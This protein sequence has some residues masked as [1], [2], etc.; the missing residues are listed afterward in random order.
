LCSVFDIIGNAQRPQQQ[1]LVQT[2]TWSKEPRLA[3]TVAASLASES[4]ERGSEQDR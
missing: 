3:K 2:N 4:S 1:V